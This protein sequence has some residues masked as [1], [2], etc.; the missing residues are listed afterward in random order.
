MHDRL[1]RCRTEEMRVRG[2]F[3]DLGYAAIVIPE[4]IE[5]SNVDANVENGS[6]QDE[7][8]SANNREEAF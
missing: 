7:L 8:E 1:D 5:D 6:R 3:L 2:K 4:E